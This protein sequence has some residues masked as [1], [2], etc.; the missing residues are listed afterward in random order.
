MVCGERRNSKISSKGK[1]CQ[2]P[3]SP[4][5]FDVDSAPRDNIPYDVEMC[6]NFIGANINQETGET[7]ISLKISIRK[8]WRDI[9]TGTPAWRI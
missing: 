2:E 1:G 3:R 4:H 7:W 8:V 9:V 6:V 5:D